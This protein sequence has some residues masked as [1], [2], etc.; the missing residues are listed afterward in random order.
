MDRMAKVKINTCSRWELLRL[1]GMGNKIA[2]KI[3]KK[4]REKGVQFNRDRLANIPC[5]VISPEL[6]EMIDYTTMVSDFTDLDPLAMYQRLK[7]IE[8]PMVGNSDELLSQKVSSPYRHSVS[9]QPVSV[10]EMTRVYT[11]LVSAPM[12]SNNFL[13][14]DQGSQLYMG[15]LDSND[16]YRPFPIM[17]QKR[18]VAGELS[19]GQ[20]GEMRLQQGTYVV[21]STSVQS[22]ISTVCPDV[23]HVP[24]NTQSANLG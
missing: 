3:C 20:V 19:Q 13:D 4:M 5:L 8:E 22:G 11:P 12:K 1:P 7:K 10:P 15:S 9:S 14:T 16:S 6:F 24:S 23:D 18:V 2:D 21:S 17:S